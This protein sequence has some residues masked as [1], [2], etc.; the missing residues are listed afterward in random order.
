MVLM[1]DAD[2]RVTIRS[3]TEFLNIT[4]DVSNCQTAMATTRLTPP[5]KRAEAYLEVDW[6]KMTAYF[7]RT[8]VLHLRLVTG[9]SDTRLFVKIES[10]E[11]PYRV[12]GIRRRQHGASR[13]G[14]GLL[15]GPPITLQDIRVVISLA[16]RSRG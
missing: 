7:G 6:P 12:P 14:Q 8:R 2:W 3:P 9:G 13:A 16:L 10:E 11:A 15:S 5:A 1:P 4:R